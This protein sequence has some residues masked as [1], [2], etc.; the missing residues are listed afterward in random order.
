MKIVDK[1]LP[2]A[3]YKE[4][5]MYAVRD[6]SWIEVDKNGANSKYEK[7]LLPGLLVKIKDAY[8]QHVDNM[9][10]FGVDPEFFSAGVVKCESGYA[11]PSH[12]DSP[13]KVISAVVYLSPLKGNAT[14]FSELPSP[15]WECNRLVAWKN[16][17]Q[18]KHNYYNNKD[19]DRYTLNIYQTSKEVSY[20]VETSRDRYIKK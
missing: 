2:D 17:G 1:F 15:E 9:A 10:E 20:V 13:S 19:L 16:E 7:P 4:V 8:T 14:L 18:C 6:D 11:Y 5:M 12:V 3:L